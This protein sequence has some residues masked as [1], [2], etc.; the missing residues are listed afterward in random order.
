MQIQQINPVSFK[1]SNE[2]GNSNFG[3]VLTAGILGLLG[4]GAMYFKQQPANDEVV[5]TKIEKDEALPKFK[6]IAAQEIIDEAKAGTADLGKI[7]VALSDEAKAIIPGK[8]KATISEISEEIAKLSKPAEG[9]KEVTEEATKKAKT[10]GDLLASDAKVAVETQNESL[11][12][13][14]KAE[15]PLK[16][17]VEKFEGFK[18]TLAKKPE[19][20]LDAS[21]TIKKLLAS[22]D[23][24]FKTLKA[25]AETAVKDVAKKAR[26]KT[27]GIYGG[28]AALAL[29][30]VTYF[31]TKGKPEEA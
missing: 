2:D 24:A 14:F 11:K 16:A 29:G 10:L 30:I 22:T 18:A 27:A 7:E 20:L 17:V 8:D 4:G 25:N 6:G 19:E 3:K 23:E 28:I 1:G 12:T 13:A 31:A 21:T 26:L 5:L 15:T 9:A